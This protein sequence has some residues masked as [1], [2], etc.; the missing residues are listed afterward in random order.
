MGYN[1]IMITLETF[2]AQKLAMC[3]RAGMHAEQIL[4][5]PG[6]DFAK[7]RDDNLTIYR[8][9]KRLHRFQRPILL[10]VSR[11]T[12]IG[13]ALNQTDPLERDPGTVACIASG[14]QRGAHVFRVHNVK[15]CIQAVKTLWALR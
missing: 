1:D 12:V 2:F 8:E 6:I 5:D 4:L 7:Q 3:A 9:L 15:A 14:V 13:H 10:P 11:K